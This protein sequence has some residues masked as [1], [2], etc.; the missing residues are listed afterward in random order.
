MNFSVETGNGYQFS[1]TVNGRSTYELGFDNSEYLVQTPDQ[2]DRGMLLRSDDGFS[3]LAVMGTYTN[4]ATAE[5]FTVFPSSVLPSDTYYVMSTFFFQPPTAMDEFYGFLLL[6]GTENSTNVTI[7]PAQTVSIPQ[8]LRANGCP[9]MLEPGS[10]CTF[11]L[12]ELQTLF[13]RSE[14]DPTGTKITSTKPLAV[15][16][17][18]ECANVPS[19][20]GNCEPLV[21]QIPPLLTWGRTFLVNSLA[22][23]RT[24]EWYKVLAAEESTTVTVYCV[25]YE[26]T[27]SYETFSIQLASSHAFFIEKNRTCS[28]KADKPVLLML[29]APNEYYAQNICRYDG[30]FMALVPPV[31]QYSY[32][33]YLHTI[34]NSSYISITVPTE[35]CPNALCQV[36]I[37]ETIISTGF[38]PIYCSIDSVCGY[39]LAYSLPLGTHRIRHEDPTAPLGVIS[40]TFSPTWGYGTVVGMQLN[41][42][43]GKCQYC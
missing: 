11:I 43:A 23:R 36:V 16:S 6:T 13:L 33:Y 29:L 18:H 2:R 39:A 10:S 5:S 15:F 22:G 27:S 17:G 3:R 1:A 9:A 19:G 12:Q 37:N 20:V 32:D 31:E 26:D 34:H 8:D 35:Y 25:R 24:G 14:Q 21:E 7:T 30:A 4:D 41:Q 38:L 28:I 40:Y 42:V